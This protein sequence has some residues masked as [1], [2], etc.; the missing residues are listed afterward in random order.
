MSTQK[1]IA[2][3]QWKS[4]SSDNRISKEHWGT[5]WH[6]EHSVSISVVLV[7]GMLDWIL[8]YLCH[9]I[10]WKTS[11]KLQLK[12]VPLVTRFNLIEAINTD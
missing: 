11:F 12:S 3:D 5:V 2:G 6:T 4:S 8:K 7:G 10:S 1:C 9:C